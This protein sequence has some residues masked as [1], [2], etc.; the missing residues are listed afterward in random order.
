MTNSALDLYNVETDLSSTQ[1]SSQRLVLQR[2][3]D[4]CQGSGDEFPL[5]QGHA[6]QLGPVEGQE[7][8]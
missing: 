5:L 1:V 6:D 3:T 7:A 4:C 2:R 8:F